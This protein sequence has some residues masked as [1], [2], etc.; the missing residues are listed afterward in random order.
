MFKPF[1]QPLLK[2]VVKPSRSSILEADAGPISI[3]D[4]DS[5]PESRPL[6]KRKL[7]IVEDQPPSTKASS[8]SAALAPRKPLLVVKNPTET[9]KITDVETEDPEGYYMVLW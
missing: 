5:E 3:P 1:K 8:S 4:S 2:S 6:K 7:L 9:K